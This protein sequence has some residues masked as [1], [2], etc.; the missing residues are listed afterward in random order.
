[1]AFQH[2]RIKNTNVAGKVPGAD[3]IDV[4]ELCVNLQ[5]H[6]LFSKDADGNIFE[7]GAKGGGEVPSGGSDDRPGS[8]ST[9]DLYF[10]TDLNQL[11]Y[12]DGSGWVPITSDPPDG[13]GYVKIS[14]DKM[15][16]AL[17]LG[18]DGGFDNIVLSP[19]DGTALFA[20]GDIILNGDGSGYFANYIDLR[21]YL[22]GDGIHIANDLT[23][24]KDNLPT[25]DAISVYSGGN[26]DGDRV[27][28]ITGTGAAIVRN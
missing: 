2:I 19:D 23:I 11:L 22:T 15:L 5:D 13:E 12:W 20:G 25:G 9:G 10:D 1:M 28:N 24:R 18:P 16:G 26:T 27:A 4:A 8:P 21:N 14:G 3:K 6:K 7:L 17:S